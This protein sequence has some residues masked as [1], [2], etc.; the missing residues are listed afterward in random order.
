MPFLLAKMKR[1]FGMV[2]AAMMTASGAQ[3]DYTA[4]RMRMAD[5]IA[6]MARDTAAETGRT[7]FSARVMDAMRRVE[8]HRFVDAESA[9]TAYQN[10][11]LAIGNNQTISQPYIV[12]LMT[13]LLDLAPGDRVLEIGTGS[14]YQAAVLAATG[15]QVYSIEIIEPLAR[16]A[17]GR[18]RAAGYAGVQLRVGDGHQGWREAAPFDRII[19]TAAARNVPPALV[20]QLKPGGRMVIPVGEPGGR[21]ELLLVTKSADGRTQA[22][23]MLAVRFVPMTGGR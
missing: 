19:V 9:R 15:A 3:E 8:R 23:S 12:A 20:D 17:A 4:A 2:F 5:E 10:T 6:A 11:P 18:L 13:D 16:V 14:G 21:Q 22:R 7:V 1:L